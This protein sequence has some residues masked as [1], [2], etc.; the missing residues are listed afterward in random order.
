MPLHAAEPFRLRYLVASA[1]YG[2]LPLAELLPELTKQGTN[3]L[4]LWPRKHGDQREQA[5]A[6]GDEAFAALLAQHRA[7]L[8]CVSR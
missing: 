4:D 7:T 5:A 2:T 1:M 3:A 8:R 6:L